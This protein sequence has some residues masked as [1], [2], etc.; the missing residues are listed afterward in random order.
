MG[1][2][3]NLNNALKE[4]AV[5]AEPQVGG[6]SQLD[7]IMT[8]IDL[9]ALMNE[10][11]PI[12]GDIAK[13]L[14]EQ[15]ANPD[16]L[17][18]I[19]DESAENFYI[20]YS[21]LMEFCEASGFDPYDAVDVITEFYE[22]AFP[23]MTMENFS[24]VF[25]SKEIYTEACQR[26]YLGYKNI[27]YSAKFFQTCKDVGLQTKTFSEP[28]VTGKLNESTE[29]LTETD[30]HNEKVYAQVVR[31][32]SAFKKDAREVPSIKKRLDVCKN[33]IKAIEAEIKSVEKNGKDKDRAKMYKSKIIVDSIKR[34]AV[35]TV[36]LSPASANSAVVNLY[37]QR[38]LSLLKRYLN[39]LKGAETYLEKAL[40]KAKTRDGKRD[41]KAEKKEKSK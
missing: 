9:E 22:E 2:R 15:T 1:I 11:N 16:N 10:V 17:R 30:A 33:E 26:N 18:I 13:K 29:V 20:D 32:V 36:S 12:S 14:Q 38:Y 8:D 34:I 28:G 39:Q 27:G 5:P 3:I 35:A 4:S 41:T 31:V 24:V 40:E 37:P 6:E 23:N 7:A 21:E 19:C 25:P